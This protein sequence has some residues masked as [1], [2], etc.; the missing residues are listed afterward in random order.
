M[1]S[2]LQEA[3]VG[4]VPVLAAG[5]SPSLNDRPSRGT[6]PSVDW[7]RLERAPTLQVQVSAKSTL[8]VT[9]ARFDHAGFGE[10][11]SPE[12]EDALAIGLILRE[13][14]GCELRTGGKTYNVGRL[15]AGDAFFFDLKA[16]NSA[17][18]RHPFHWLLVKLPRAFLDELATEFGSPPISRLGTQPGVPVRNEVFARFTQSVR[19]FVAA[20]AQADDLYADHLMLALAVYACAVHGDLSTPARK[21]GGLTAWQARVA[22]EV[23]DAHTA[24]GIGLRD[25]A[26]YCGLGASQLSH[27]FKQTVGTAPHQ[28]LLGRR[29]DKA[30]SFL[31]RTD[32]PIGEIALTCGFADQSHFC[33][34]FQRHTR[35]TPRTWRDGL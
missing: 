35:V 16:L 31:S 19:N 7:L 34:V 18:S 26:A 24:T 15:L 33:R 4:S 12:P 27:A 22:K 30:K 11:D 9:E 1:T 29:V 10:T 2:D 14:P 23:I 17:V 6:D 32:L 13:H 21:P 28:W 5:G 25:L 20:H 8:S 3:G